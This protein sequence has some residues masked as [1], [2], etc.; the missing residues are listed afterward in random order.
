M[1]VNVEVKY[2]LTDKEGRI[3]T[4]EYLPFTASK[5]G[6]IRNRQDAWMLVASKVMRHADSHKAMVRETE[7]HIGPVIGLNYSFRELAWM[8]LIS[9]QHFYFRTNKENKLLDKQRYRY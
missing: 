8:E 4:G 6:E 5:R 1:Q 2:W 7:V 3:F 9:N